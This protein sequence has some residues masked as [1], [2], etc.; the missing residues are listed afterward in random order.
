MAGAS[1]ARRIEI[2]R[3]WFAAADLA[4]A[5][6]LF[7]LGKTVVFGAIVPDAPPFHEGLVEGGGVVAY[8][9]RKKVAQL[10]TGNPTAVNK[11]RAGR[12][13]TTG[14]T[15]FGG[16]GFPARFNEEGTIKQGAHPFLTPSLMEELPG[17]GPLVAAAFK[18]HKLTGLARAAKG[19]VYKGRK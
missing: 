18:K 4:A 19:D 14:A 9:G 17:V 11:P 16:F 6:A 1:S 2:N 13:I 15:V 3:Q 7:E 5:D 10:S 12:L 8:L